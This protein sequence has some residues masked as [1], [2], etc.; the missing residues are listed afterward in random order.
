MEPESES[1][2]FTLSND[3]PPTR[4]KKRR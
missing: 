3:P 4:R 1:D 2:T